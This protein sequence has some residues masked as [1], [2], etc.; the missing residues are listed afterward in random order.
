MFWIKTLNPHHL[1]GA[2]V[3]QSQWWLAP[4]LLRQLAAKRL[5]LVQ[6][7]IFRVQAVEWSLLPTFLILRISLAMN[8]LPEPLLESK[9]LKQ[10]CLL[11]PGMKA[12]SPERKNARQK[13]PSWVSPPT[14]LRKMPRIQ[15]M[16]LHSH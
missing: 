10:L 14:R 3:K 6:P 16:H 9:T 2:D 11:H 15:A 12:M 5:R 7:L 1:S 13:T 8:P 4:D